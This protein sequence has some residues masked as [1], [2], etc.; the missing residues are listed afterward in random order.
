MYNKLKDN[1]SYIIIFI[2]FFIIQTS[3]I[4]QITPLP[5]DT[6]KPNDV[7]KNLFYPL[8]LFILPIYFIIFVYLPSLLLIKISYSL[9][10]YFFIPKVYFNYK[11]PLKT[12]IQWTDKRYFKKLMIIRC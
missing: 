3:S 6:I 11:T 9:E 2:I 1:I 12:I 5:I 10:Y 8:I 7:I 4:I